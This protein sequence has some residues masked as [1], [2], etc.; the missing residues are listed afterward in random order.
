MADCL[1]CKEKRLELD[2]IIL[3]A[4][5]YA[6]ENDYTTPIYIIKKENGSVSFGF[7]KKGEKP[8]GMLIDNVSPY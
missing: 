3:E 5:A 7:C 2:R 4:K 6:I 1:T 8:I